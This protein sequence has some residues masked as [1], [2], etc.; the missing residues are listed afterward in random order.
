MRIQEWREP[1]FTIDG[2]FVLGP[3]LK[4]KRRKIKP[5]PMFLLLL[6][7]AAALTGIVFVVLSYRL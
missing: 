1:V 6:S 7:G 3:V 2:P 4:A 5:P